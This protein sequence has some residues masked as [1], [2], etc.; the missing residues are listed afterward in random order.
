MHLA[1]V[2]A[3]R[4]SPS[5]VRKQ[6]HPVCNELTR[7]RSLPTAR[8]S[9]THH[10]SVEGDKLTTNDEVVSSKRPKLAVT[11]SPK[12]NFKIATILGHDDDSKAEA[13]GST[14]V[15]Q[16]LCDPMKAE[17]SSAEQ[18]DDVTA[19]GGA[20]ATKRGRQLVEAAKRETT[21]TNGREATGVERIFL[22]IKPSS[23]KASKVGG[24]GLSMIKT[25]K[26]K[27]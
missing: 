2:N 10:D 8:S 9:P 15:N 21:S 26:G 14:S 13:E 25:G 27:K 20:A 23:I 22:G 19:V 7:K 5:S 12:T 3:H 11:S 17:T 18:N 16:M 6:S 24:K 4:Q 1:R